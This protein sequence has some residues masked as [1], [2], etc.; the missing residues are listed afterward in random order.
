MCCFLPNFDTTDLLENH[1]LIYLFSYFDRSSTETTITTTTRP[2]VS[3]SDTQLLDNEKNAMSWVMG[4][5][6]TDCCLLDCLC[7]CKNRSG[8]ACLLGSPRTWFFL[9]CLFPCLRLYSKHDIRFRL[10]G[11]FIDRAELISKSPKVAIN[12]EI[13]DD[14]KVDIDSPEVVIGLSAMPYQKCDSL[15][16]LSDREIAAVKKAKEALNYSTQF[17]FLFGIYNGMVNACECL[18]WLTCIQF[19]YG[20]D[21][22]VKYLSKDPRQDVFSKFKAEIQPPALN[23]ASTEFSFGYPYRLC[24]NPVD[25]IKFNAMP[26]MQRVDAANKFSALVDGIIALNLKYEQ[27]KINEQETIINPIIEFFSKNGNLHSPI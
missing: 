16:I 21:H 17:L 24:F 18:A 19:C 7:C 9:L 12:Y 6:E 15:V 20:Y 13:L 4:V 2:F 22:C 25:V 1:K 3:L 14:I 11:G 27:E 26:A 10:T 5:L 23:N 8:I